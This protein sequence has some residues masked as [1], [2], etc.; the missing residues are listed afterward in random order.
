MSVKIKQGYAKKQ[1]LENPQMSRNRAKL[2][3]N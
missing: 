1:V 3:V 2:A